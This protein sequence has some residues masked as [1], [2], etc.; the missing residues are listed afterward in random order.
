MQDRG[1]LQVDVVCQ[2]AQGGEEQQASQATQAATLQVVASIQVTGVPR[3]T[4]GILRILSLR[5]IGDNAQ[6]N[7]GR[8]HHSYRHAQLDHPADHVQNGHQK[9]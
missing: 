1:E 7:T 5:A 4:L 9:R 2:G 6:L 8:Y 3:P